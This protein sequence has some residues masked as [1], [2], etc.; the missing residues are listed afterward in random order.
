MTLK[1]KQ[2]EIRD[3]DIVSDVQKQFTPI[4]DICQFKYMEY[5]ISISTAGRSQ[6]SCQNK[7]HVFD[8]EGEYL[9]KEGFHTVEDAIKYIDDIV[10]VV[11]SEPLSVYPFIF[12]RTT[13]E[14]QT[15]YE[16]GESDLVIKDWIVV[17]AQPDFTIYDS[18]WMND[19]EQ[20]SFCLV[21]GVNISVDKDQV[22]AT[23]E[24]A[25]QA[26]GQWWVDQIQQPKG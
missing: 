1:T 15:L 14:S 10:T 9:V 3:F 11:L 18:R 16:Q 20:G 6:S 4:D 26:V 2:M 12:A 23:F 7:V 22:F 5:V 19:P 21:P 25:K 13:E 8:K 24:E 17:I